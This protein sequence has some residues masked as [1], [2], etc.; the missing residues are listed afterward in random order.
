MLKKY[1][2]TILLFLSCCLAG[3]SAD[4]PSEGME[5]PVSVYGSVAKPYD[6][7]PIG[8]GLIFLVGMSALYFS[9]KK[10]KK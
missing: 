6:P 4:L 5:P 7:A 8:G 2:I 1:T 3:F 10:L 9:H